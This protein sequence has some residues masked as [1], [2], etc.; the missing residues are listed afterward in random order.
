MQKNWIGR[1]EGTRVTFP[2]LAGE[3]AAVSDTIEVFTTRVDTIF[4]ATCVFVAP[5]HEM[6]EKFAMLSE[7]AEA[8]RKRVTVF[9]TQDR[10][11]RL[12]GE[13]EKEGFFTGRYAQESVYRR[14]DT[15]L[16]RELRARAST[17]RARSW[18]CRRTISATS[19]SRRNTSCQSRSSS[20]QTPISVTRRRRS[21]RRSTT[22]AASSTRANSLA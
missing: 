5:E 11:A 12:T 20:I 3:G 21:I 14:A 9:R 10:T 2:V 8:F 17:A 18:R 6:V 16:G 19:S 15:D 7:D 22:T 13:I 4:G 1:S